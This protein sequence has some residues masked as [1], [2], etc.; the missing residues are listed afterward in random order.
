MN[1]V[2]NLEY[3]VVST[4]H[5]GLDVKSLHVQ[6]EADIVIEMQLPCSTWTT[7]NNVCRWSNLMRVALHYI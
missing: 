1:D 7:E 6:H 5:T 3:A 4:F 2:Y